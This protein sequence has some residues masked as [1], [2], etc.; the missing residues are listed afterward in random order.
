M[1][2]DGGERRCC[3][4][5]NVWC[6]STKVRVGCSTTIAGVA[7][8]CRVSVCTCVLVWGGVKT[9]PLVN[10]Q[11]S[12]SWLCV[13][14]RPL[15]PLPTPSDFTPQVHTASWFDRSPANCLRSAGF[16]LFTYTLP[17]LSHSPLADLFTL[18]PA[19]RLFPLLPRSLY[20]T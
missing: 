15:P 10:F 7:I 4:E 5:A 13:S 20:R 17:L 9:R 11:L 2:P 19:G 18:R 12:S 3:R 14:L 16:T 1:R 8:P 6:E